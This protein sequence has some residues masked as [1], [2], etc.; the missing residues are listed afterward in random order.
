MCMQMFKDKANGY[1]RLNY[2]A[3][4]Q[5]IH[6]RPRKASKNSFL[7]TRLL[8]CYIFL[9][10]T[11]FYDVHQILLSSTS[12]RTGLLNWNTLR[13]D[14]FSW[15][16]VSLSHFLHLNIQYSL[17]NENSKD[18]SLAYLMKPTDIFHTKTPVRSKIGTT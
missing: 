7:S 1:R 11:L 16:P 6:G 15:F 4:S 12:Y 8:L 5:E 13:A 10:Y 9:K 17:H 2:F 18:F 3:H 14:I